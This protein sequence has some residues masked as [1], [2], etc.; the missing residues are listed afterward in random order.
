MPEPTKI[1]RPFADSGDK[2]S[3]PESSGSLGFASWQEGF[4]AITGTPFAQGGVA[5]KRADFNGI[6]NALSAATV[7]NQQGGVYAYDAMT[8]YEVGNI[9]LYSGEIYV[10]LAANGPSSAVKAPTDAATWAKNAT[11]ANAVP[12]SGNSST[13]MTGGFYGGAGADWGI[14]MSDNAHMLLTRGGTSAATGAYLKLY[15]ASHASYPARFFLAAS[16]GGV[17]KELAGATDGSLLW[18]SL[19]VATVDTGTWT[20]VLKGG[21]TAGAF[22]GTFYG[23]YRKMGNLVFVRF[24]I[25]ATCTTQPIGNVTLTGLPFTPSSTTGNGI[26]HGLTLTRAAGG[27]L[28][29]IRRLAN[30]RFT[31]AGNVYFDV[32]QFTDGLN[33]TGSFVSNISLSDTSNPNKVCINANESLELSGCGWYECV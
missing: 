8:D 1:P 17:T 32:Y 2:N 26:S 28:Q 9:V 33:Y 3:I 19:P 6:F 30:I 25:A 7:W 5:P 22:T 27:T 13:P 10:C 18:D 11:L 21:T 14:S 23:D 31:S 29:S 24:G 12:I 15:G 4:P 16:G 20:P